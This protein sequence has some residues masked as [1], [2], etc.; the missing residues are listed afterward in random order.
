[1]P[2]RRGVAVRVIPRS[3]SER[4]DPVRAGR[5]WADRRQPRVARRQGGPRA[6]ARSGAP[7]PGTGPA[8]RARSARAV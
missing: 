4:V 1:L 5:Y 6:A 3:R 8:A 2:E 7:A